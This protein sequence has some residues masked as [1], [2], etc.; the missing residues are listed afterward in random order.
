MLTPTDIKTSDVDPFHSVVPQPPTQHAL[1]CSA[2]PCGRHAIWTPGPPF[3]VETDIMSL[4]EC[5]RQTSKL[6]EPAG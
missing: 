6:P 3:V 2:G 4:A 1:P 5:R